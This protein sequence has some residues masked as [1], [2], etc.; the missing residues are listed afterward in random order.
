MFGIV[1]HFLLVVGNMILIS[2][3]MSYNPNPIIK[4]MTILLASPTSLLL[5]ILLISIITILS[6]FIPIIYLRRV[7]PI[8]IIR[9]R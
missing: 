5:D 9:N 2:S 3:F 1:S 7:K 4:E 6:I 8:E